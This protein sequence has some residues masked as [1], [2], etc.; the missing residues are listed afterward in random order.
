LMSNTGNPMQFIQRRG[1]VLRRFPNKEKSIIYD[2][3]VVP[4][5]RPD[6]SMISS[7]R[8]ILQKELRRFEEF[9]ETA[10]NKRQA[11]IKLRSLRIRY[12]IPEFE[13]DPSEDLE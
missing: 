4:S 12:E 10:D 1:R 2:F 6:A 13:T 7:D 8:T 5:K 9:A 3:V 11:R